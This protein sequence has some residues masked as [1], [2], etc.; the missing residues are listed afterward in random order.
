MLSSRTGANIAGNSVMMSTRMAGLS[1]IAGGFEDITPADRLLNLR[2][3]D[4]AGNRFRRLGTD[5]EPVLHTL[6]LQYNLLFLVMGQ[7][8][9]MAKLLDHLPVALA[10]HV[11]DD[12]AIRGLVLA[13][14]LLET[15]SNCHVISFQRTA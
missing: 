14:H 3:L 5:A 15:N 2:A 4:H 8:V 7:R 13:A 11:R 1:T 6:A 12:N 10:M 9:I